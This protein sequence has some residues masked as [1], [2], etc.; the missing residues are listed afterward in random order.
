M[1]I[2]RGKSFRS[3]KGFKGDKALSAYSLE[4]DITT[5]A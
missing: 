5:K 4:K 1:Q 3:I 2:L